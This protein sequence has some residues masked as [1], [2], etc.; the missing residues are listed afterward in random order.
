M[1]TPAHFSIAPPRRWG[2]ALLGFLAALGFL[3]A[4]ISAT[5]ATN[6]TPSKSKAG[7][8]VSKRY[9]CAG[10][11]AL[12]V[13]YRLGPERMHAFLPLQGK[14]R[15]LLW[16]VDYTLQHT[17]TDRFS[18]GQYEMLV[19]GK[20]SRVLAVHRLPRSA[21]GKPQMLYRHCKLR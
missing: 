8:L 19:Q 7:V 9:R 12:A 10:G 16:D 13:Q 21:S 3:Y 2:L 17:E 15:E 11:H 1:R 4:P 5:A 20:F 18:D 6:A 14:R